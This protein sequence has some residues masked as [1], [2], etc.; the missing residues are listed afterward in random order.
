M[1]GKRTEEGIG[2]RRWEEK[3]KEEEKRREEEENRR[4]EEYS[5]R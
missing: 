4:E 2:I 3:E 5:I 1:I